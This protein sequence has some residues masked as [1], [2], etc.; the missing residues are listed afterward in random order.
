VHR[1]LAIEVFRELIGFF[2]SSQRIFDEHRVLLALSILAIA[3]CERAAA[4]CGEGEIVG[5]LH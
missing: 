2:G 4:G 1:T 3:M 5:R